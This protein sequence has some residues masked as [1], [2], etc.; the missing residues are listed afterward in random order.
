MKR[1]PKIPRIGLFIES[2]RA[3]GRALLQGVATY[4]HRQSHWSVFWEPGGLEKAWPKLKSLDLSGIILRDVDKL[5]EVFAFG[6]PAVVVGHS[7]TEIAGM[8]NVITDSAAIGRMGAEHLLAC[9]FKNFAYCGLGN[10]ALDNPPWSKNREAAFADWLRKA[11]YPCHSYE[12]SSATHLPSRREARTLAK[13][14]ASLPKPVGLMVGNDDR[15]QQVLE[16]CKLAAL[17]IPDAVGIVGVDN[18]EVVCGLSD[19]PLSSIAL[20]FERAGFEAAEALDALIQG[21]RRGGSRI[22]VPA[23][24][25][26]A[27]RSTDFVAVA[28]SQLAKALRCIRDLAHLGNLG[29]TE[30]ARAVGLSRRALERRFRGEL[31]ASIHQH[32][33]KVRTDQIARLLVETNL[34]V[35]HIATSLGFTDVRHFARYFRTGKGQSPLAF[36]QAYGTPP[37]PGTHEDFNAKAQ[38]RKEGMATKRHKKHK[39]SGD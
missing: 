12:V 9:G 31:G 22:I 14:L 17:A 28:D 33:R 24:H 36:R 16:A 29:V 27:R 8:V 3:S 18:D 23:T 2:S 20:N 37:A 19:P 25:V 7:K 5:D 32:I 26:V 39:K 4:V 30:V 6:I 11:G 38:R 13:W 35:A 15:A 10:S 34:P 21:R 1:L